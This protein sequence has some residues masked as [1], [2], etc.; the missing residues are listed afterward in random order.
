MAEEGIDNLALIPTS[1]VHENLETRYDLDHE[2]IPY[3]KD[4]L[5]IK[6]ISRVKLPE[7][8]LLFVGMLADLVLKS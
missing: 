3:A 5:G 2:L 6:N 7:A 8:D 1:F 4:I